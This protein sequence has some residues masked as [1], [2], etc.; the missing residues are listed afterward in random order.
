MSTPTTMPQQQPE[1]I[2]YDTF[3]V[4]KL[5]VSAD[6]IVVRWKEDRRNL[7]RNIGLSKITNPWLAAL[8]SSRSCRGKVTGPTSIRGVCTGCTVS[9]RLFTKGM[10]VLNQKTTIV[11]G[12]NTGTQFIVSQFASEF[13]GEYFRGY[14]INDDAASASQNI[15]TNVG[16]LEACMPGFVASVH[17]TTFY[18]CIGS[19]FEHYA[20]VS[21]FV[22]YEMDKAGIPC[23]P[24][25][26]WAWQCENTLNSVELAHSLGRG[27]F[28][29]ITKV[30]DFMDRAGMLN[31]DTVKGI[32]GQLLSS[33]H[34]LSNYGFNHGMPSLANLAFTRKIAMYSYDECQIASPLTLHIIPSGVSSISLQSSSGITRIFHSGLGLVKPLNLKTFPTIE[35][36]P[37]IEPHTHSDALCRAPE[38][39]LGMRIPCLPE[40]LEK[41][42]VCYKIGEYWEDFL[43]YIQHLGTPLFTSS[44]DFYAFLISL[45]A[46][47]SFCNAL[48]ADFSLHDLFKSLFVQSELENLMI[49]ITALQRLPHV[50]THTDIVKVL[51]KYNLR[52]DV[53]SYAWFKFKNLPSTSPSA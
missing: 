10:T 27:S 34:F 1:L 5:M 29:L 6:Q 23:V 44:Y 38:P 45:M 32:F 15:S 7:A 35:V 41:R 18:S 40:Y 8:P 36:R 2:D 26:L 21:C 3:G 20:L 42:V 16:A 30:P 9:G 46:E 49:D 24:A 43:Y 52:C 14:K 12:T 51:C 25:F 13:L 48:C 39:S 47:Q 33:L 22:E 28:D 53:I 4:D 50:P 31:Y 37:L 19:Y 17:D 11:A